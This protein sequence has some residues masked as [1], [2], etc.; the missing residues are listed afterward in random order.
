MSIWREQAQGRDK[1]KRRT[2]FIG[3]RRMFSILLLLAVLSTSLAPTLGAQA[4]TP[5]PQPEVQTL[6]SRMTPEE[7]VG[8]LF[9]VAFQGTDTS[10]ASQ[11]HDLIVNYHVGG[12]VLQAAND[13]FT[14]A[15]QTVAD[16]HA[17]IEDLQRLE[18]ESAVSSEIDPT[19]GQEAHRSYVPLWIGLSQEGNGY[20]TDQILSGLTPLPDQM[21]IGATWNPD[22]AR[23]VGEVQGRELSALGVNLYFGPSLDVLDTPSPTAQ[24][25]MGTRV[26]GGDPYWVGELGRAL[27]TG[28]HTGSENQLTVI[29]KHFPGRGGSDRLPEEEVSTVRKSLEQLKQIELSPFFSVTGNAPTP[30]ATTDGLLIS[31]IRYQG[32]QGN[33]RATTRPVSF[34]SQALTQILSLPQFVDWRTAGGL[35]VSDDLGT[36]AVRDFY[37]LGGQSFVARTVAR[38][39]FL[40]GNDLLYLGQ[41]ISGDATDNH[42]TVLQILDFFTSKYRED[43]AFAQLV[44][45]SVLR[46]LGMKYRMYGDFT[47]ANVLTPQ[48]A[49]E[50]VGTSQDLAF[51]IARRGATL[52]SPTTQDLTTILPNPPQVRE[53]MVFITDTLMV[54]QCSTC[55]EQ[56]TL[57]MNALENSIL[58][59]YGPEAGNQTSTFRVSSYSFDHLQQMLDGASP[60]Y[61][62]ADLDRANWIILSMSDASRG[63][64]E[65]ISRFLARQQDSLRDQRVILFSFGAPYYLGATDISKLTAYYT[66]Y[67][68]QSP[69]VDV[70]ARLLFQELTPTGSSPVSISGIGYDLISVMTPNPN[71]IISMAL[72]LAPASETTGVTATP[73]TPESTPMPLFRIGDT[74]AIRTGIIR[75]HN[76]HPVPDGTVVRFSMMLTGE[77]GGI[78]QQVDAATAQGVARAS[79]GLDKPGLLEIRAT[80]EPAIVSDILQLDVSS[81]GAVAVTVVVPVLTETA[82]P[83]PTVVV[84]VEQNEFVT[85]AGYPRFNAWFITILLLVGSAWLA[86]WAVSRWKGGREGVRWALCVLLGGAAAYNYMVLGLP[87]S[88]D[89]ASNQGMVGILVMTFVGELMGLGSAWLW[90]QRANATK[91]QAG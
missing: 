60:P 73:A 26:F 20:P 55:P 89:L 1:T 88:R 48:S 83:T 71:Q 78:L 72:D 62:E 53:R 22:I 37:S 4:Q 2:S 59:L 21:A 43:P 31:H 86:Y 51:D 52:I 41:I 9:L 35:I 11:I 66:L 58:R 3:G 33:I 69:V 25:D 49:L 74:I 80:S 13:N 56:A 18:W 79:F 42:A 65:L 70:A 90:M 14:A 81:A 5:T 50:G 87:G 57:E 15:P 12:V 34:D 28:L 36:Q 61:I 77:G 63:Q 29:A 16:A 54:K 40:A 75:D 46:I 85:D 82:M 6:F 76:G 44:D 17:L 67:S 84:P 47:L 27:I 68:K 45:A 23:Q 32:F 39:A 8:Q 91:S 38:D 30:E 10:T 19:V 64:A 7:R 24:G